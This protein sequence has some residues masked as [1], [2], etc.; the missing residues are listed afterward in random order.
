MWCTIVHQSGIRMVD[1]R[2]V[3]TSSRAAE[4]GHLP[5]P[6]LVTFEL[7]GSLFYCVATMTG[8]VPLTSTDA[9]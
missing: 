5:C 6:D 1:T 4:P 7:D 8:S 9:A 2:L 3:G